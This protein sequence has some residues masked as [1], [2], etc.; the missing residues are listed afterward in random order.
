MEGLMK[1]KGWLYASAFLV[2]WLPILAQVMD[3]SNAGTLILFD[4][5]VRVI[6]WFAA[7]AAA[8]MG[9]YYWGGALD[10]GEEARLLA[11]TLYLTCPWFLSYGG[12]VTLRERMLIVGLL[13]CYFAALFWAT[14]KK[15][16]WQLTVL[17]GL[18]LAFIGYC[19]DSILFIC[20]AITIF[21]SFF[22]GARM[23]LAAL[24]GVL[25]WLP[26]GAK[27]ILY[28][29]TSRYDGMVG[30]VQTIAS[31]GYVWSDYLTCFRFAEGRPGMGLG[32]LAGLAALTWVAVTLQKSPIP[33]RSGLLPVCVLCVLAAWHLFPWDFA[34]RLGAWS[35]KLVSGFETPGIFFGFACLFLA[36]LASYAVEPLLAEEN[37]LPAR[38]SLMAIW[39]MAIAGAVY[40]GI[41]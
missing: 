39:L 37:R 15:R 17:A 24:S 20:A 41:S 6:L 13:P 35:L 27:W 8:L 34:Q 12:L 31:K 25:I 4:G 1:K 5:V 14:C 33:K 30:E 38:G 10:L 23:A 28:L 26:K 21:L 32:L 7:V 40:Q 19:N 11:V 9:M 36:A 16:T 2:A 29:F 18:I 22:F 3:A